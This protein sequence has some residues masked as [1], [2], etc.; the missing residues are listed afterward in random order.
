MNKREIPVVIVEYGKH[1]L[2]DGSSDYGVLAYTRD[3]SSLA[4]GYSRYVNLE[5]SAPFFSHIGNVSALLLPIDKQKFLFAK[6]LRRSEG[7]FSPERSPTNRPFTQIKYLQIEK[8]AFQDA[9][10]D[11]YSP[12][13]GLL[14]HGNSGV[15]ENIQE[16]RTYSTAGNLIE[17]PNSNI[18]LDLPSPKNKFSELPYLYQFQLGKLDDNTLSQIS[19]ISDAINRYGS[20]TVLIDSNMTLV[21]RV[22]IAQE[23]QRLM[24]PKSDVISVAFDL[25]T[26][27]NVHLQFVE[28]DL[29]NGFGTNN[30][31]V[32]LRNAPFPDLSEIESNYSS[33]MLKVFD[34][35]QLPRSK[36]K[37]LELWL[38]SNVCIQDTILVE[39]YL[40]KIS[41]KD[42]VGL[43][44][45]KWDISKNNIKKC[46][47][48]SKEQLYHDLIK[49]YFDEGSEKANEL[50][51]EAL[52]QLLQVALHDGYPLN[53]RLVL[54]FSKIENLSGV[55]KEIREKLI[56]LGEME[57][58]TK[59]S[60]QEP[61][62]E[63]GEDFL[64]F[65]KGLSIIDD[66]DI[67]KEK[68]NSKLEQNI[69]FTHSI[70]DEL[71]NMQVES[72]NNY[73]HILIILNELLVEKIIFQAS[74]ISRFQ[75][76]L[77][78][79]SRT[80]LQQ[81]FFSGIFKHRFDNGKNGIIK[82]RR[83]IVISVFLI[84][85]IVFF[86]WYLYIS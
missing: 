32:D 77:D 85:V 37:S 73:S 10:R 45:L 49:K 42:A 38:E 69:S 25:I 55:A 52:T 66:E 11:G 39:S 5:E 18:I 83:E 61:R 82:N 54:E 71:M 75:T 51:T 67:I 46:Y 70:T 3:A 19:L 15:N 76:L 35:I 20:T 26:R 53:S 7:E 64:S 14:M 43:L 29:P 30:A 8:V 68:L 9:L 1:F 6:L 48:C 78:N 63:K 57:L 44:F 62:K 13:L 34:C 41:A 74:E 65:I 33:W 79:S 27:S 36:R 86:Y 50:P 23:V 4:K 28:G 47:G 84:I 59:D 24:F 60:G 21:N 80:F 72:K 12:L 22:R 31:I 56:D 2:H 81:L 58:Q 16:L 17:G 40:S